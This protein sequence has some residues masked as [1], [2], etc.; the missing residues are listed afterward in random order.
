LTPL[1]GSATIDVDYSAGEECGNAVALNELSFARREHQPK[2][3]CRDLG[4]THLA[5]PQRSSID[6]ANPVRF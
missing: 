6:V 1:Y 5:T 4:L 2:D 3:A